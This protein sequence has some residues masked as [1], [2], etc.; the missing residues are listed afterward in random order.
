MKVDRIGVHSAHCCK[1]CGC[2][3]GDPDC[4]VELGSV[5]AEYLCEFCEENAR[6]LFR[7]FESM[8]SSDLSET[9]SRLQAL[10]ES[11]LQKEGR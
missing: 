1:R 6:D 11:K 3:Y 2:K 8:S 5:Q 7:R 10:R 9:I 4:P